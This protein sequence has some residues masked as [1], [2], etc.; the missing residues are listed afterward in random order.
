MKIEKPKNEDF[1][2]EEDDEII[3]DDLFDDVLCGA[4]AAVGQ[5]TD[6]IFRQRL[7]CSHDH[8]GSTHGNA[9][10][11][12]FPIPSEAVYQVFQPAM[13]VLALM[14]AEGDHSAVTSSTAALIRQKY[15]PAQGKAPLHTAAEIPLRV[16]PIAV[17]HELD[18]GAGGI[19]V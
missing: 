3:P 14:D 18:G 1:Y 5:N 7:T 16:P 12:D 13:A 10:E 15:A 11:D 19:F 6:D 2:P 4:V 8:G 9:G 17:E